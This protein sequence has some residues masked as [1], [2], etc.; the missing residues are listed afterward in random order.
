MLFTIC[1]EKKKE[2]TKHVQSIKAV[3]CSQIISRTE[4]NMIKCSS[5]FGAWHRA[6]SVASE[7]VLAYVGDSHDEN[8]F[9]A[10]GDVKAYEKAS[11]FVN[12]EFGLVSQLKQYISELP[13]IVGTRQYHESICSIGRCISL[14]LNSNVLHVLPLEKCRDALTSTK[15]VCMD[16][17]LV[18]SEQDGQTVT[19]ATC[20]SMDRNSSC[21]I[22]L[23]RVQGNI[24]SENV[25]VDGNNIVINVSEK[26]VEK[27]TSNSNVSYAVNA[28]NSY[29]S[30]LM[31]ALEECPTSG[32]VTIVTP[33]EDVY[34]DLKTLLFD[35]YIDKTFRIHL[36][37]HYDLQ[38]KTPKTQSEQQPKRQRT[39]DAVVKKSLVVLLDDKELG[40]MRE[41]PLKETRGLCGLMSDWG[42]SMYPLW[43]DKQQYYTFYNPD[44][45]PHLVDKGLHLFQAFLA[46]MRIFMPV[47]V[48]GD[49]PELAALREIFQQYIHYRDGKFK[50]YPRPKLDS[51]LKLL[52]SPSG[53]NLMR[54]PRLSDDTCFVYFEK[55]PIKTDF[56]TKDN[57]PSGALIKCFSVNEQRFHNL[58]QLEMKH[59]GIGTGI[60]TDT[61]N[62]KD[63]NV[64]ISKM[65]CYQIFCAAVQKA[66]HSAHPKNRHSNV[67][68]RI[69]ALTFHD[70]F[71]KHATATLSSFVN[72]MGLSFDHL[73]RFKMTPIAAGMLLASLEEIQQSVVNH[74]GGSRQI[75]AWPPDNK[76]PPLPP[77]DKEFQDAVRYIR[78][79][80]LQ[81][82][83]PKC[84][85]T[86]LGA[87]GSDLKDKVVKYIL[88]AAV[89]IQ[90]KKKISLTENQDPYYYRNKV[91]LLNVYT[92]NACSLL[93][94]TNRIYFM[95]SKDQY[96]S[97]ATIPQT[98]DVQE[99]GC[100]GYR[101]LNGCMV[102]NIYRSFAPGRYEKNLHVPGLFNFLPRDNTKDWEG[103][104][105]DDPRSLYTPTCSTDATGLF[106]SDKIESFL[107][108]NY[109]S[110]G[111]SRRY[112]LYCPRIKKAIEYT[113]K[114]PFDH[115]I[116]D[117]K[118]FEYERYQHAKREL[119]NIFQEMQGLDGNGDLLHKKLKRVEWNLLMK[120]AKKKFENGR[121]PKER[122]Y[123]PN[124]VHSQEDFLPVDT[125]HVPFVA[126]FI[127]ALY[128]SEN[129]RGFFSI[130]DSSTWPAVTGTCAYDCWKAFEGSYMKSIEWRRS[131]EIRVELDVNSCFGDNQVDY[132]DEKEIEQLIQFY[133]GVVNPNP[134]QVEIQKIISE[135]SSVNGNTLYARFA[136]TPSATDIISKKYKL[137]ICYILDKE[138][139]ENNLNM[140]PHSVEKVLN[141]KKEWLRYLK[142]G[143]KEGRVAASDAEFQTMFWTCVIFSCIYPFHPLPES[144]T[145]NP[146]FA[147]KMMF[148]R[149]MTFSI[150]SANL[151]ANIPGFV[152]DDRW[153]HGNPHRFFQRRTVN[154]PSTKGVHEVDCSNVRE[155]KLI[156]NEFEVLDDDALKNMKGE[157]LW[158]RVDDETHL[159]TR[160]TSTPLDDI[161]RSQRLYR[162]GDTCVYLIDSYKESPNPHGILYI[163]YLMRS[164]TLYLPESSFEI[165]Q[166]PLQKNFIRYLKQNNINT[167]FELTSKQ[168]KDWGSYLDRL[169]QEQNQND[170]RYLTHKTSPSPLRDS[171][172]E[173]PK[174]AV[175]Q[176]VLSHSKDSIIKAFESVYLGPQDRDVL[177]SLRS[178][179]DQDQPMRWTICAEYAS[180]NKEN[181]VTLVSS[182]LLRH[183]IAFAVSP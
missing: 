49:V 37:K 104:D 31:D 32:S 61:E 154:P 90:S 5:W 119:I 176:S 162:L 142:Q 156:P 19:E 167:N 93:T 12:L 183:L 140:S 39:E 173:L 3:R 178:P 159:L 51:T 125:R 179:P 160:T 21:P 71:G 124:P 8:E 70:L 137:L 56:A 103:V 41:V 95:T 82:K 169:K 6:P 121:V 78:E 40:D 168:E 43:E 155:S 182:R 79:P 138:H 35:H 113:G 38:T 27:H 11:S 50:D 148:M 126:Q 55:V 144:Q 13:W 20:L 72:V 75:P 60:E 67:V 84:V 26:T 165:P 2:V 86:I 88:E 146:Y 118:S 24:S 114:D 1:E 112:N 66:R 30:R 127:S 62:S 45:F 101:I 29:F 47:H 53:R 102:F 153:K 170:T 122:V 164:I 111:T 158:Y 14:L 34:K 136:D 77:N 76:E 83:V 147:E 177:N 58:M 65:F 151:V 44:R 100:E 91:A 99:H 4:V 134:K 120:E 15:T 152:V 172:G 132:Y 9:N 123:L 128:K 110:P 109:L 28:G 23:K 25:K 64:V 46:S 16:K 150:L 7:G 163:A 22:Y 69:A 48:E 98:S 181:K 74:F 166:T 130:E 17:T 175:S 106:Y 54:F 10:D 141:W 107:L 180:P 36:Q 33:D 145:K 57:R 59:L 42:V 96:C 174:G 97:G 105:E 171:N 73:S 18:V 63:T 85:K 52:P 143:G 87:K 108:F 131:I 133:T 89:S 115:I 157:K 117:Q 149:E 80:A 81:K 92:Y 161:Q 94:I 116:H 135:T 68:A 129:A 139:L